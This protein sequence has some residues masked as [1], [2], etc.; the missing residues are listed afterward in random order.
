VSIPFEN[1]FSVKKKMATPEINALL[2]LHIIFKSH[3][4]LKF[5]H[6]RGI[7]GKKELNK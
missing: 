3:I 4:N 2:G 5:V 1:K 7:R 6:G